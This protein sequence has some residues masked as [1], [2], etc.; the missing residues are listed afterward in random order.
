MIVKLK[1]A[2]GY[3]VVLVIPGVFAST[4]PMV[5]KCVAVMANGAQFVVEG[6][7]EEVYGLIRRHE[8]ASDSV[9]EI[10]K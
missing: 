2:D 10:G 6:T 8:R 1:Q 4:T 7:V 9:I 5:G 3:S